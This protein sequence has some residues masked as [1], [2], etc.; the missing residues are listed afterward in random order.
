MSGLAT[1]QSGAA[2]PA[3]RTG[4]R[5][6]ILVVLHQESSTPGRV[7]LILK[8]RG[9]RLDIRRP[10]LGDPLPATL[11]EHRAAIFFGGP[12]SANDEHEFIRRER[13]WIAVPLGEAKPFLG[14]CLGAQLLARHA[15]GAVGE[16]R[17][18]IVEIG[19]F[20]LVATPAGEAL[21]EW[22]PCVHQWH[23][24]WLTPPEGADVLAV[25]TRGEAQAFRI[26]RCAYGV[27]FHPELTLAMVHRW[28]VRGA[29]R[30]HL[31]GAQERH[32]HFEGRMRHDRAVRQWLERFLDLWLA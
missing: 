20:P 3:T 22:P 10:P 32:Q 28:T 24:E 26:G 27:Q 6:R 13:D 11:A 4:C 25:G 29:N 31:E 9:Y 15:G 8:H 21:M 5:D 14:I 19:Y 1:T 16:H 17:R 12:M 23:R 2:R 18:G 30:F 7:G